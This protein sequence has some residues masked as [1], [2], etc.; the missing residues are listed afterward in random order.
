[1]SMV[2]LVTWIIPCSRTF[3]EDPLRVAILFT[4]YTNDTK[5]ARLAV[6]KVTNQTNVRLKRW[7]CCSRERSDPPR[8]YASE[9]F[10]PSCILAP[11]QSEFITLPAPVSWAWGSWKVEFAFSPVG[12][13]LR[14]SDWCWRA[15]DDL[16]RQVVPGRFWSPPSQRLQSLWIAE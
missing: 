8:R 14:L 6:F 4:G 15:P 1:L 16:T 3:E 10:A 12:W 7:G 2:A 9:Y 11:S 13:R 5:R